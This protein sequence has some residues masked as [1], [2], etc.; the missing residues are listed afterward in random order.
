MSM[1]RFATRS[2]FRS[3]RQ[4]QWRWTNQ[5]MRIANQLAMLRRTVG[6]IS[7]DLLTSRAN[8]LT[9]AQS[10]ADFKGLALEYL[11]STCDLSG[12]T[13]AIE[14]VVCQDPRRRISLA[15]LTDSVTGRDSVST[16][17]SQ[18]RRLWQPLSSQRYAV[19]GLLENSLH[20]SGVIP[21]PMPDKIDVCGTAVF[22]IMQPSPRAGVKD[23]CNTRRD[24]GVVPASQRRPCTDRLYPAGSS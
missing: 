7:A 10:A 24:T 6:T 22:C 23:C 16:N 20:A 4:A 17:K 15:S 21:Y 14:T 19:H 9:T 8:P 2:I 3:D 12:A 13:A 5:A 1:T 11:A 18:N